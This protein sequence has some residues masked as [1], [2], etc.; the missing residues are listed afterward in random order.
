[1]FFKF[2]IDGKP[3][4]LKVDIDLSE[5]I[6]KPD[7]LQTIVSE[8]NRSQSVSF[9][10]HSVAFLSK[11]EEVEDAEEINILSL[12]ERLASMRLD[13]PRRPDIFYKSIVQVADVKTW[14]VDDLKLPGNKLYWEQDINSTGAVI[15]RWYGQLH[16]PRKMDPSMRLRFPAL[17]QGLETLGLDHFFDVDSTSRLMTNEELECY[18]DIIRHIENRCRRV[19][20]AEYASSALNTAL[21]A[22]SLILPAF[23]W[24]TACD[25]GHMSVTLNRG[26]HIRMFVEQLGSSRTYSYNPQSDVAVLSEEKD[27]LPLLISEVDSNVNGEDRT[28]MILQGAV[29]CRQRRCVLR[30]PYKEDNGILRLY[31]YKNLHVELHLFYADESYDVTDFEQTFRISRTGDALRLARCLFNFRDSKMGPLDKFG[32][33]LMDLL[34]LV[35]ISSQV[36]S[37]SSAKKQRSNAAGGSR[38]Q[39]LEPIPEEGPT[40]QGETLL[41]S[42][43]LRSLVCTSETRIELTEYKDVAAVKRISRPFPIGFVKITNKQELDAFASIRAT[44]SKFLLG[45]VVLP[46]KTFRISGQTVLYLP[47]AGEPLCNSRTLKYWMNAKGQEIDIAWTILKIFA[48]LHD[49][50]I[51]HLD[52]KPSNILW[53]PITRTVRAIDFDSSMVLPSDGNYKVRGLS[54]TKGY[55]APEVELEEGRDCYNVYLADA[56]SLGMVLAEF[57]EEVEH[58]KEKEFIREISRALRRRN[59]DERWTIRRALGAWEDWIKMHTGNSNEPAIANVF[60]M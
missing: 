48:T 20:D 26:S 29:V 58:C 21:I 60:P 12:E 43:E 31:I 25:E 53:D 54:G 33:Q 22:P 17:F 59:I 45:H 42:A 52:I 40:D 8:F 38:K 3:R 5:L 46:E 50:H 37:F 2:D 35:K 28:R 49:H 4:Y 34:G 44:G 56:W 14:Q 36:P 27:A 41:L 30:D 16:K 39:R 7:I 13:T 55:T 19:H 57:V 1:M 15:Q 32:K 10:E 24:D 18:D 6:A 51:A 11:L 9:A 47:Y 23:L